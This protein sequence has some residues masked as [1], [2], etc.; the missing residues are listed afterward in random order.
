MNDLRMTLPMARRHEA[1][2]NGRVVRFYP[3]THRLLEILMIRGPRWT[4]HGEM[5]EMMYPDPDAEPDHARKVIDQSICV[6]R[7]A[8]VEISCFTKVGY[9]L[10]QPGDPDSKLPPPRPKARRKPKRTRYEV[11]PPGLML[12]QILR[13]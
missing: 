5:I 11:N 10:R 13:R 6:L 4:L 12:G 7:R 3:M 9:R 1:E 8:G 2:I